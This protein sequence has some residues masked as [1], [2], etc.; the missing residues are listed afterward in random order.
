MTMFAPTIRRIKKVDEITLVDVIAWITTIQTVQ[1]ITNI[2]N[3]ES[4]DVIDLITKISEIAKI[5]SIETIGTMPDPTP[6]GSEGIAFKQRTAG[7]G[8]WVTPT[9]HETPTDWVNPANAYDDN[10]ASKATYVVPPYSFSP[11]LVLTHS[12]L[13][14]NKVRYMVKFAFNVDVDVFKDGQWVHVIY[15]PCE[16]GVWIEWGFNQGSVTKIRIRFWNDTYLEKEAW[17]YEVDF[18]TVTTTGGEMIVDATLT[19]REDLTSYGSVKTSSGAGTIVVAGTAGQNIK[20]YDGGYESGVDCIHFF[21]FGTSTT[22]TTKRF[23][24]S[25]TKG[26]FHKTFVQPRVG[27]AGDTLYLYSLDADTNMPVDVGYVKE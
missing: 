23:L 4:I 18:W 17:I 13:T 9:A 8:S 11:F 6:K 27:E 10:E 24:S 15:G 25:G 5:T 1:E 12:A 26:C 7:A 14:S 16:D 3:V 2:K 20:V 22:P 19:L 21:Y